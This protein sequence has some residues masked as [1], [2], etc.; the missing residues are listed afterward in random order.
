MLEHLQQKVIDDLRLIPYYNNG[1]SK[2]DELNQPT[3]NQ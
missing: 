1:A 3:P 2:N